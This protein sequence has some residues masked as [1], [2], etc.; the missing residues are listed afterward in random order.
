MTL[1]SRW[2]FVP[3]VMQVLPDWILAI[4]LIVLLA[5]TA[6]RTLRKGIKTY[7]KETEAQQVPVRCY[8]PSRLSPLRPPLP[9]SYQTYRS[10]SF[11]RPVG[12]IAD[13]LKEPVRKWSS[14][15][16]TLHEVFHERESRDTDLRSLVVVVAAAVIGQRIVLPMSMFAFDLTPPVAQSIRYPLVLHLKTRTGCTR[17]SVSPPYLLPTPAMHVHVR[18]AAVLSRRSS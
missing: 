4:M 11:V 3:P 6:N 9:P 17:T 8:C 14:R 15:T 13:D 10:L 18:I 5:A 2:L 7:N 1:V 16:C 12:R